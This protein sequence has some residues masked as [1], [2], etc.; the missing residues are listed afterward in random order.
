MGEDNGVLF[1]TNSN[2]P[3]VGVILRQL[4]GKKSENAIAELEMLKDRYHAMCENMKKLQK[5]LQE[6]YAALVSTAQARAAVAHA[7]SIMSQGTPLATMAGNEDSAKIKSQSYYCVMVDDMQNRSKLRAQEYLNSAITYAVE[8]DKKV[9][10]RIN[11]DLKQTEN[12]RRDADHY[13]VKVDNLN[14]N[15]KKMH[16]SNKPVAFATQEK[17]E[18]NEQKLR[19]AT[20]AYQD[21]AQDLYSLMEEVVDR[22]W[23]DLHPLLLQIL[24]WDTEV[25]E[26]EIECMSAPFK[27]LINDLEA[28]GK[29]EKIFP[30][31]KTFVDGTPEMLSTR[32]AETENVNPQSDDR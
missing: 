17:L 15:L 9:T 28:L 30:R 1:K 4:G 24:K 16:E 22:S 18:R 19:E 14:A 8:W 7:L 23:R 31:L 11:A 2:R 32:L 29:K 25:S 10:T 20:G 26:E 13:K 6:R 27:A 12:L 21:A 5:A 3:R